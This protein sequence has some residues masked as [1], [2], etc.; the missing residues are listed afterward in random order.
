MN[1]LSHTIP[2]STLSLHDEK[3]R[4]GVSIMGFSTKEEQDVSYLKQSSILPID[5]VIFGNATDTVCGNTA[6][7]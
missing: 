2:S 7:V 5:H 4:F 6:A 3:I 1:Y